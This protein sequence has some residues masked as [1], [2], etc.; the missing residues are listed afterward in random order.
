MDTSME[1]RDLKKWYMK[2]EGRDRQGER[3]VHRHVARKG[4]FVEI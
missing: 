2:K 3:Q 4:M 1:T